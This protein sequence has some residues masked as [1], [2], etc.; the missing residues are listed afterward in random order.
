MTDREKVQLLQH[1]LDAAGNE[2]S[3]WLY[4]A[5]NREARRVP[6]MPMS[7]VTQFNGSWNI[8]CTNGSEPWGRPES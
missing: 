5:A 6:L 3:W 2:R 1:A 7:R 8:D 4:L